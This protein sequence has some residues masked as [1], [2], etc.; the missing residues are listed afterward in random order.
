MLL[1]F[2]VAREDAFYDDTCYLYR[3]GYVCIMCFVLFRTRF[4]SAWILA[5]CMCVTAGLG[6]YPTQAQNI[7]GGGPTN[8]QGNK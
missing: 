1:C 5:E 8:L 7:P 4:Y 3:Y 6:A 2:Q